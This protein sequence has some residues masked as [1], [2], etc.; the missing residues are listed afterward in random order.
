MTFL[1]DVSHYVVTKLHCM[2]LDNKTFLVLQMVWLLRSQTG[3]HVL[4]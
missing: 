1:V 4:V 3:Y 2:F